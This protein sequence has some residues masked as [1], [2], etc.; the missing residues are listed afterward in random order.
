VT[1]NVLGR[2]V[3]AR[4]AN[5]RTVEWESLAI[6]FVMVFS[7]NT[8]AAAPHNLLATISLSDDAP[9]ATEADIS[10]ALASALPTASAIRVKDALDAVNAV[11]GKVL[12][13][14]RIAGSV[15]LLA[16]ALVLAGAL[17]TAQRRRMVETAILKALGATQRRV[18]V[19]H[20]IEYAI[21]AAV[22][23]VLAALIGTLLSWLVL[24]QIMDLTF[25]GSLSAVGQALGF[26]LMLVLI[27][28][29]VG[30]WQVLR[31]PTVPLLRAE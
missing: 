1:V 7:P 12:L 14:V 15:A 10:R 8:L 11:V 27:F 16:G 24:T 21:L 2:N 20:A 4:I 18:L 13:A 31:S 28:G 3:T 25:V 30:T 9:L 5:L 22:T 23:A 17:A 19:A 29:G 6:N 26:S